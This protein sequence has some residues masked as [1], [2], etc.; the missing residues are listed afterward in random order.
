MEIKESIELNYS[1]ERIVRKEE[2]RQKKIVFFFLSNYPTKVYTNKKSIEYIVSSIEL[3]KG[4][5]D[6]KQKKVINIGD[7]CSLY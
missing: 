6:R 1:V 3:R 5:K 7:N 2:R 4:R